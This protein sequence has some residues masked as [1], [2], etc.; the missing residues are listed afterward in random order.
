[1]V[2]YSELFI[3]K[4]RSPFVHFRI[5]SQE[6]VDRDYGVGQRKPECPSSGYYGDESNRARKWSIWIQTVK[7]ILVSR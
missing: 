3:L 2:R 4:K 1:V 6:T 5:E 7:A